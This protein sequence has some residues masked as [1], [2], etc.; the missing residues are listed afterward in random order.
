MRKLSSTAWFKMNGKL[1]LMI[2]DNCKDVP[3]VMCKCDL[4]I[5]SVDCARKYK[6]RF[7]PSGATV[8]TF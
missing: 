7:E 8:V 5:C 2:A 4:I 3:M 6:D 1:I